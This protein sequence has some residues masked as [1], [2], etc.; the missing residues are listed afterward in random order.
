MYAPTEGLSWKASLFARQVYSLQP[1]EPPTQRSLDRAGDEAVIQPSDRPS[2]EEKPTFHSQSILCGP[3][4]R[5]AHRSHWGN[6]GLLPG[7]LR[8]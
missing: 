4:T 6:L 2:M 5:D 7:R 1:G 8:G 3:C